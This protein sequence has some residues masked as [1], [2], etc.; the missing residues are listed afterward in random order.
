[1]WLARH[2]PGRHRGIGVTGRSDR[3]LRL[4]RQVNWYEPPAVVAADTRKL[5]NEV[6]ARG[7]NAD[8]EEAWALFSEAQ[9]ADAYCHAPPGLYSRRYWSYWGLVL[10]G[11]PEAR[12]YPAR[13]PEAGWE[14]PASF[15][16]DGP[17]G[18][19]TAADIDS[20]G[21]SLDMTG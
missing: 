11:D 7:S 12:P 19:A 10:L 21:G 17:R 6:M 13:Y 3:L 4:A 5:L 16:N 18:L 20:C 2:P 8:I 15:Q 1:M 14:W 9:L